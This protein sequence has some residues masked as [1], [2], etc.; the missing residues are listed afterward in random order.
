MTLGTG[1]LGYV[2]AKESSP[3]Q[4][5]ARED[6]V[7]PQNNCGRHFESEEAQP[8]QLPC[9]YFRQLVNFFVERGPSCLAPSAGAAFAL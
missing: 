1:H 4:I 7:S 6:W 2:T 5:R 9:S 8:A 3:C